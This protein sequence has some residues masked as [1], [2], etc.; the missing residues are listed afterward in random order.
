[1][2]N[3]VLTEIVFRGVDRAKQE[4]ILGLVGTARQVIDFEALLPVPINCWQGSVGSRHKAAFRINSLEWCSHNW[5]TK[6]NAY[7]LDEGYSPVVQ[8]DDGLILLFQTAWSPPYGWML[9]LWHKAGVGFSYTSLDEGRTDAI[10]GSF[11]DDYGY[12]F[13]DPWT[14][15]VAP[16]NETHRMQDLYWG[17][18]T[19]AEIR[20]ER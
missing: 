19:A 20:R 3:H 2:P 6:W 8:V 18:E 5:G 17:A 4:S 13:D 15:E 14:E 11:K 7:G 10:C 12:G 1:M 9:A 16:I